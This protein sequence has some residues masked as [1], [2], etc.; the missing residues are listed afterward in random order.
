MNS[1]SCKTTGWLR[2]FQ[3]QGEVPINSGLTSKIKVPLTNTSTKFI[4]ALY[5]PHPSSSTRAYKLA[6]EWIKIQSTDSS[7]RFRDRR[8]GQWS[9]P[10]DDVRYDLEWH[11]KD[12]DGVV[13]SLVFWGTIDIRYEDWDQ[14]SLK[15]NFLGK[16]L[17]KL[18]LVVRWRSGIFTSL[19][20]TNRKH[21]STA[22]FGH[23]L[24]S[25]D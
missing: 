10:S 7:L 18:Q 2:F 19:V 12:E 11:W 5:E 20:S 16:D 22:T 3:V 13:S 9:L 4:P 23:H 8:I 6:I 25:H 24:W 15:K 1:P 17:D 14:S 21:Q